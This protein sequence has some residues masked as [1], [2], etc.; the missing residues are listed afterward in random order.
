MD[1]MKRLLLGVALAACVG[2]IPVAQ[3]RTVPVDRSAATSRL[4]WRCGTWPT[5]ES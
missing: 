4:D 3:L 1:V 5:Q 2:L